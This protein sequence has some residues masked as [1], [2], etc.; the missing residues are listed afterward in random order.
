M[1]AFTDERNLYLLL[2]LAPCGN[3]SDLAHRTDGIPQQHAKFYFACIVLGL[4]FLQ[5]HSLIHRDI[6]PENIV[7]MGN[8]YLA[9]TDFGVSKH[10]D[11][12]GTWDE[13]G[14]VGY[15]PPELM[16]MDSDV[17]Q[18]WRKSIDWWSAAR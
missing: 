14:T 9:L 3:L 6:K 13:Q 1:D 10:L 17:L 4:E 15:M 18:K 16:S 11:E 5:S 8:G 2:E 7:I 12:D